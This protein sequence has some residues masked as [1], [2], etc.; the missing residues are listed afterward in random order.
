MSYCSI[1]NVDVCPV[2]TKSALAL[3]WVYSFPNCTQ[4]GNNENTLHEINIH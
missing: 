4:P 2:G 1:V 3:H